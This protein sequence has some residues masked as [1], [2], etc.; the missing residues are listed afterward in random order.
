MLMNL[1]S[2]RDLVAQVVLWTFWR[3]ERKC[4][5]IATYKGS[6]LAI[7][8]CACVEGKRNLE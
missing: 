5:Q 3:N 8:M 4:D 7:Q 1:S 6:V 2:T